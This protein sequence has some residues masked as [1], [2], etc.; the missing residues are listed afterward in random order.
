MNPR[1]SLG[2][3]VLLVSLMI[4]S[5]MVQGD[6][7]AA[8]NKPAS[9]TAQA[10]GETTSPAAEDRLGEMITIPAGSFLM[11]NNG[12]EG[13]GDPEELP[14]H[15]VDLPTYQIG[16]YEVTRGQ[17]RKFIEAGGYDDPKYWF[18]E[19]WKWKESD[20][21][22]YAGM[23]GKVRHTV[24]PNAA[25]KRREPEH[26]ASEQEWIGHGF[27]HPR[28]TQTD[29]HPVVGV[30]YYEAE[31]YCKRAGGRFPADFPILNFPRWS[32]E[33]SR[34][35]CCRLIRRTEHPRVC[36]PSDPIS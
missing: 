7:P 19:G 23:Q 3:L 29:N 12:H 17:F 18:P 34:A 32:A 35:F 1:P 2:S 9:E 25:E 36:R 11:G 13:F 10:A 14:R 22:D 31:A 6:P 5:N 4:N 8:T 30:T 26:W 20:V 33:T 28:F 16:K 15:P 27:N 21:I 24:R